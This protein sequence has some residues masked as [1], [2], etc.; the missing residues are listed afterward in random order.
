MSS[1][2][3]NCVPL[4][5]LNQGRQ[6][7]ANVLINGLMPNVVLETDLIIMYS[8]CGSITEAQQ[9][10][11]SMPH[12]NMHSWNSMIAAHVRCAQWDQALQI[13]SE[14]L[15]LGYQ[16][17]HFTYPCLFKA[18]AGQRAQFK[19][20]KLH[21]HVIKMGYDSHLIV[22][23]AIMDMYAKCERVGDAE[24][25]FNGISQRDIT[26]WNAMIAGYDRAG[27]SLKALNTLVEMQREGVVIDSMTMPSVLSACGHE[28][29]L[30]QGKAIHSWVFKNGH[31]SDLVVANAL[32]NMYSKCGFF[33]GAKRV[34]LGVAKP[35]VVTWTAMIAC[36]GFHGMG[37]DALALFNK[38]QAVGIMPN[39]LT[40]TAIL[41]SCSH[42]GLISEGQRIF[43]SMNQDYGVKHCVE[44][45]ACMVDLLGRYGCIQ[46]A[47]VMI[48]KMPIAPEASVWGAL[49]NACRMHKNVEVG[50]YAAQW[51]FKY[52]G[53][54]TSNY[55]LLSSI[56]A[57][58]GRRLDVFKTRSRMREM[59]L[60]KAPGCSWIIVQGI[61]YRFFQED[62]LHAKAKEI[63]VALRSLSH[64]MM[65]VS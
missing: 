3:R 32:I 56:Y 24:K 28:G 64:V 21:N 7:H 27:L 49:L 48:K 23:C 46:E 25:V 62:L 18:C 19:G 63:Y 11:E 2:L 42:S 22:S 16:P 43:A 37:N 20:K 41:S 14:F 45:Y 40:F 34:F 26:S 51:L 58:A 13:F 53:A 9:V 15:N 33:D 17:D 55:V 52:E 36:Y 57:A 12:R 10:F 60:T 29:N 6:I 61:V 8:K 5:A 30:L 59:G 38:M 31:F 50:E 65:M 44:H 54:N 35:N 1:L 39:S 4:G 47:L